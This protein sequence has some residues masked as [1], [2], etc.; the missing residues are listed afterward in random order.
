[1]WQKVD[2]RW[3]RTG[4]VKWWVSE[5]FAP[6]KQ[7]SVNY[8]IQDL[9]I[10]KFIDEYYKNSGIYKIVF[11]KWEVADKVK[12]DILIFT[13]KP[14]VVLWKDGKK[15]EKFK[16]LLAKK[17]WEKF[18]VIIKEISRPELSAR[19]MCEYVISQLEKRMPYRRVVKTALEKISSK[20]AKWVKIQIAGRLNWAEMARKETFKDGRIPLQTL[21]ADVDYHNAQANTKYWV[22]WIKVWIYKWD[23]ENNRKKTTNRNSKS[24]ARVFKKTSK[25]TR[26]KKTVKKTENK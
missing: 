22:L 7:K 13:A 8:M 5:Y 19:I 17:F 10:R 24:K 14:A 12:N 1:M 25:V 20:W 16:K 6:T 21:R 18:D 2:P 4:I 23:I 26:S 15:I 9:G 11:R 3:F